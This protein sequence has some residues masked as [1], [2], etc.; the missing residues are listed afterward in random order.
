VHLDSFGR[1]KREEIKGMGVDRGIAK[2]AA[3]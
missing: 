3:S 1:N 2:E